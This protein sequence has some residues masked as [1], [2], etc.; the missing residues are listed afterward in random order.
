MIKFEKLLLFGSRA[1][2][3]HRPNSDF[4]YI[5]VVD[6]YPDFGSAYTESNRTYYLYT[7]KDFNDALKDHDIAVLESVYLN[8]DIPSWFTLDLGK[9]RVSISTVGNNSWVKGKKKLIISSDYDKKSALKSI[10]HSFRI[11][12]YGIQ[13]AVHGG[14][15]ERGRYNWLLDELYKLGE[16]YERVGLWDIIQVRYRDDWKQLRSKFK[17]L[18]PKTEMERFKNKDKLINVLKTHNVS[19]SNKL[20][21]EITKIFE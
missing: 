6:E 8:Y 13:L 20:I 16:N 11:M 1:Y 9:L 21:K 15:V 10:Y 2:G 19:P 5:G 18:A 14:I 7:K 17:R 3:S 4:D 12:D